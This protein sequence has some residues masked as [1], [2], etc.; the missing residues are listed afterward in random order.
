MFSFFSA[1]LSHDYFT[2]RQDRYI[3]FKNSPELADFFAK[4]AEVIC[5]HSFRIDDKN[6][7]HFPT[8]TGVDPLTSYRN[9]HQFRESFHNAISDVCSVKTVAHSSHGYQRKSVQKSNSIL[10]SS[11]ADTLVF[12]LLQMG[13]YDIKQDEQVT[14]L[15]LKGAIDNDRVCLAT[16]YFNPPL[17][18]IDAILASSG[19]YNIL[20]AAPQVSSLYFR[21]V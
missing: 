2:N 15:L 21:V 11:S 14:Q 3:L 8:G 20:A 7:A 17:H 18:Y 1:N 10:A 5:D 9:S 4:I 12:P 6:N 13:Q 19:V 16:G